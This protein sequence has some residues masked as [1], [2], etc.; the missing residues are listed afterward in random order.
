[1]TNKP[2]RLIAT[3]ILPHHAILAISFL[4]DFK[5]LFALSGL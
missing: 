3:S 4:Q 2:S 5:H 1:M